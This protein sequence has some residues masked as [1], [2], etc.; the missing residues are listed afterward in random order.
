LLLFVKSK[1]IREDIGWERCQVC[2]ITKFVEEIK[3][4]GV[5]FYNILE[6]IDVQA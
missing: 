2:N 3:L 1:N 5:R 4:D 6:E